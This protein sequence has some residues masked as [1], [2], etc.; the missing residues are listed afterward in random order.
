MKGNEEHRDTDLT[1]K[2]LEARLCRLPEV[3][4]P[5]RLKARLLEAIPV[6]KE[7]VTQ[8]RPIGWFLRVWDFGV[9]AAAAVLIIASLLLVNYGL[10][11]PS[12]TLLTEFDDTSLCYP[13]SDQNDFLFSQS[14]GCIEK[15]LYGESNRPG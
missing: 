3:D 13:R 6:D 12:Q 10:S 7:H 2:S 9:T 1:L 5:E 11:V 4:V 8:Q 15:V 14:G